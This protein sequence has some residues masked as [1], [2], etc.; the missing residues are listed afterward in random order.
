MEN[1]T[2][3]QD[4]MM[5]YSRKAAAVI[6][7]MIMLMTMMP[8]MAFAE[9]ANGIDKG[10]NSG[11]AGGASAEA[12]SNGIVPV[13]IPA[14]SGEEA[15]LADD[16][17][18]LDAAFDGDDAGI[19]GLLENATYD[20][21]ADLGGNAT[22]DGNADLDD[23]ASFDGN[24][25]YDEGADFGEDEALDEEADL[26]DEDDADVEMGYEVVSG[27]AGF[28]INDEEVDPDKLIEDFML[29][30]E[31]SS[32]ER[33]TPEAPMSVKGDRLTGGPLNL[34]NSYK[35][36]INAVN[37]GT[38]NTTVKSVSTT[39]LI[40][41]RTYT[42]KELGLTKIANKK[43]GQWVATEKA[44]KKIA[45]MVDKKTNWAGVFQSLLSDLTSD[46]YWVAW[47]SDQ[48][49][50][51]YTYQYN[52]KK[53]IF[54]KK[55]T[56]S[57]PVMPEYAKDVNSQYKYIYRLDRNKLNATSEARENAKAIVKTFDDAIPTTFEGYTPEQIDFNRLWYY[58]N[59]ICRLTDYDY[60]TLY[61]PEGQRYWQGA[62]SMIYVF[63]NDPSTKVVCSGYAR[64]LKYLCDLSTFESDWIDCQLAS[65][66]AG[67]NHMWCTV[68]MN[69]GENYLVDP[70]WMDGD[71]AVD[72]K[73]FLRGDPN[74]NSSTFTVEG[75]PR[76]Y[77]DWYKAAFAPAE[78]T[79]SKNSYY[80]GGTDRVID[81]YE[82]KI[83]GMSKG[84]KRFTVKWKKVSEALGALYVDGYQIQYS[85][86]KSFSKPKTVTVKGYKKNSRTFK[87]LKSKKTY[88]VRIRTY[89]N[90]GKGK[91][92]SEWSPIRKVKT[93]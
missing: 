3:G 90:M 28:D 20:G 22:Y 33:M 68:R 26:E 60:D 14:A 57:L 21:N 10:E 76:V 15:D 50:Y 11:S 69:D 35:S 66:Y 58:S 85:T 47:S 30:G 91:Y 5:K 43:G 42:A 31:E 59:M 73:W 65:G 54:T 18:D 88:Y 41:K 2:K 70:T 48:N 16:A 1:F 27:S 92:Y 84:K 40:S 34:Y 62:W 39:K 80:T 83:S 77:S 37:K 45:Q 52:N 64:A 19:A 6:L 8:A 78:R 4:K 75:T 51:T 24:A 63:D 89:A 36:M 82:T 71:E 23:G 25:A 38:R 32:V 56:L 44:K 29:S 17:E 55:F 49:F 81:L 9:D 87:N 93:K 74:G 7:S 46:S 67:E 61:L 72:E 86:N 12:I 79:L 13:D 53:V